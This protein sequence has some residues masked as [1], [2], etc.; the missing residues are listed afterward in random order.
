MQL[1]QGRYLA[2][3]CGPA[4]SLGMDGGVL[5]HSATV[6]QERNEHSLLRGFEDEIPGYLLNDKIRNVLE[7]LSLDRH[8]TLR[9]QHLCYEA[10]AREQLIPNQ[11]QPILRE[12]EKCA[13]NW[14]SRELDSERHSFSSA[15]GV[16]GKDDRPMVGPR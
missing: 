3:F 4:L 15:A 10:L 1:P 11:E 6:W 2:L 7:K 8:G 5:F 9:N 16:G 12:G 13:K 14:R